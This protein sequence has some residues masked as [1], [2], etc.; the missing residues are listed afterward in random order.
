MLGKAINCI[1][2]NAKSVLSCFEQC[3]RGKSYNH[4][5]TLFF[6]VDFLLKIYTIK[7]LQY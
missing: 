6:I 5:G 1:G 7:L 2:G 4:A 3:F